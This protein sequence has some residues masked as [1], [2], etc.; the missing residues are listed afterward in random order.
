M[1][2]H[3]YTNW[4]Q[5]PSDREEQIEPFRKYFFICEGANTETFYFKRLPSIILTVV[6]LQKNYIAMDCP[7][8][9]SGKDYTMSSITFT[10]LPEIAVSGSGHTRGTYVSNRVQ[11]ACWWD[12]EG[13]S[14]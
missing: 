1:P 12:T 3:A 11:Q 7:K 4:N 13:A 6:K 8:M 14:N 5:R 10:M 2:V 9:I